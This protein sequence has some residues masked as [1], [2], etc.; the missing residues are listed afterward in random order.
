[1]SFKRFEPGSNLVIL[2][3][4]ESKISDCHVP[5]G[6]RKLSRNDFPFGNCKEGKFVQNIYLYEYDDI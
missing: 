4:F 3:T 6:P 5:F 1:M 2:A